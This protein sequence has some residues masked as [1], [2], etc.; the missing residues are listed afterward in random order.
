[1]T[2][3]YL[4][5]AWLLGVIGGAATGAVW[6]PGVAAIGVAG[7]TAGA[8]ARKPQLALLAVLAAALFAGGGMRYAEERP[9]TQER[10]IAVYNDGDAVRVRALVSDEPDVRGRTQRLR[11]S[12][13]EV[14]ADGRWQASSGGLLVRGALYPRYDYGDVL[15]LEAELETPP[16]FPG[17]DYRD[18]LARRGVVSVAAYPTEVRTIATGE[19][20]RA[21]ALLHTVRGGLSDALARTLPEPQAALA[22]GILLGQRSSIPAELTDAMNATGTSH[23]VAISGYNVSLVAAFVIAS[24]AWLI[25]RRQ[26]AIVALLAIAGYTM[27]TGASPTV[28]RA[29]IMGSLFVVATLAGRPNSALTAIA[30]A[31]A[32][33]TG[34]NPLVIED[35]SFQLSFA[36]IAG[37]VYLAPLLRAAG[38]DALRGFGIDAEA[39]GF[40]GF[41]LE[42]TAITAGA[43]AATL[44]LIA[45]NFERVSAIALISNLLVV[46]AFPLILGSAAL[47]AGTGALWEPLGEVS[48]WISWAML[49][50]MIEV[51]RFFAAVPLASFAIEGFGA[52]HAAAAY[53]G[54]AGMAW[55]LSRRRLAGPTIGPEIASAS[56][57][58]GWLL[59]GGLAV[60][61]VF[62]WSAVLSDNGGRLSMSVL[63]VGQGDAIL[64]ETPAGHHIL[65]DGGASGQALTEAL[66][67]ELPFWERTIDLVMLTHPQEDH[68]AGLIEVLERYDVREVLSTGRGNDTPTFEAWRSLILRQ[69]IPYHEARPGETIDLGDGA[70]L[71]VLAPDAEALAAD[72]INDSSLVLKLTWRK[73]SFLLTGDIEAEGEAAL[74]RNETDVR[75]QVL[76]VAHHGSRTSSSGAFLRAVDPTVAIVSVGADNTFGHPSPRVLDRLG[77]AIVL[78]TDLHGTVRIST[79]GERVWVESERGGG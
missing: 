25:G 8:L 53:L 50:Y 61:T 76:K 13:R 70:V 43:V 62:T 9:P 20:S 23:L 77:G 22:Q 11:L 48:A 47:T 57:R 78:R 16:T 37:I 60:A 42:S 46:P 36:A 34:L 40:A 21:R 54:L 4:A 12:V 65:I 52:G 79:D 10:G 17:F 19:G 69:G 66:G 74:L 45:L 32:V 33:M 35:V 6:W 41:V 2:L 58:P 39:G 59:A 64:I 71:R 51:A 31:G 7:L 63:D 73:V 14:F 1:M 30:L 5:G 56:L 28:V 3:V 49:S 26:A 72:E 44:P 18:Y 68:L 24:L 67:A 38:E 55:W 27:L 29:A 75:A 15:E